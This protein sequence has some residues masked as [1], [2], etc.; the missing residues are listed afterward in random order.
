MKKIVIVLFVLFQTYSFSQTAGSIFNEIA[1]SSNEQKMNFDQLSMYFNSLNYD[2]NDEI[3]RNNLFRDIEFLMSRI[4]DLNRTKMKSFDQLSV[5]LNDFNGTYSS[6]SELPALPT[7]V[8][9]LTN[10]A[11]YSTFDGNYGKLINSPLVFNTSGTGGIQSTGAGTITPSENLA[12]GTLATALGNQTRATSAGALAIG[13]WNTFDDAIDGAAAD[14]SHQA[15]VIG[16]GNGKVNGRSNAFEVLYDGTTT[17]AG[18]IVINSDMRLKANIISLGSTLSKLLQI[19]GKTYTMK[20]DKTQKQK[21]GVLAQD[22]EKVFP[23]LV[24]ET[25]GIK[26]VNYQGLVPVLINSIKEQEEKIERLEML[27]E[28]LLE[29]KE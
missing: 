17:I 2:H 15:F 5:L 29:A 19:D 21:I 27:V 23:E 1:A 25:K 6:L 13:Q 3:R 18:D 14:A 12:S 10:D 4:G 24:S 11:G 16:N 8:S 20:K 26:S 7:A 28:K 9:D 22:I